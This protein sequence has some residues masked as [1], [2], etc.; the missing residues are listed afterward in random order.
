MK[1]FGITISVLVLSVLTGCETLEERQAREGAQQERYWNSLRASCSQYGFQL[2]TSAFAQCVRDE[3]RAAEGRRRAQNEAD[4]R[5]WRQYS[6]SLG[7]T[8]MCDNPPRRTNCARD[9]F[10]NV[11]C[12]TQ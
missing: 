10:G 9:V 2:G 4:A 6:C 3:A 8:A 12:V 1:S 5:V 11:N 7:N